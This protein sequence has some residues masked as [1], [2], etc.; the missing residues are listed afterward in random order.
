MLLYKANWR[1]EKER[2]NRGNNNIEEK[3][4]KLIKAFEICIKYSDTH[5]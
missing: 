1:G 2:E 4:I 3:S 5:I